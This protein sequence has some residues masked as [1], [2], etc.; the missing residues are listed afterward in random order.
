MIMVISNMCCFHWCISIS[1]SIDIKSQ[2]QLLTK[3]KFSLETI[4]WWF[5]GKI[6]LFK[7]SELYLLLQL[8]DQFILD[9]LFFIPFLDQSEQ[10]LSLSF[11][12]LHFGFR[13]NKLLLKLCWISTLSLNKQ[14]ISVIKKFKKK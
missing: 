4:F 7:K 6:W 12:F 9:G 10:S 14:K 2:T 8:L 5:P 13:F 3:A 1:Y 11:S